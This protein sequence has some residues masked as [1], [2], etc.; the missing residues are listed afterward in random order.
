MPGEPSARSAAQNFRKLAE[1][2]QQTPLGEIRAPLPTSESTV[3]DIIQFLLP[4]NEA[5]VLGGLIPGMKVAEKVSKARAMTP[6]ERL[7]RE[8]Q[9]LLDMMGNPLDP[10]RREEHEMTEKAI[11]DVLGQISQGATRVP[12]MLESVGLAEQANQERGLDP[13]GERF[14]R[15]LGLE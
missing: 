4:S 12:L 13:V 14:L 2:I 1:F 8:T 5:E 3:A 11:A 7:R 6:D 15:A 10:K 9:K